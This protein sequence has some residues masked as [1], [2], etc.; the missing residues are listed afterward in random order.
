MSG[1]YLADEAGTYDFA[2]RAAR[3]L[4]AV[5]EPLVLYLEGDLGAGKTSFARGLLRALGE[6]APVRSPTYGLIAEYVVSAG[7]VVHLDLYRLQDPEE[8]E[9]LGLR[10]LVG[11]ARLW[12]VEWAGRGAGW[13]PPADAQV[14]LVVRGTGREVQVRAHTAAGRRW[15]AE[16]DADSPS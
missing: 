2:A 16:L 10:D 1:H 15:L 7:R 11:D 14:D 8:M 12:L 3:A 5:D 4:V 13:L 9:Q 6:Q